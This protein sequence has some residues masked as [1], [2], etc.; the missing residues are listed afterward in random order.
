MLTHSWMLLVTYAAVCGAWWLLNVVVT[1]WRDTDRPRFA[2]PWREVALVL[3]A[4][5][6]VLVLGQLW[7][8]GIRLTLTGGWAPVAE[9]VNQIIIFSPVIAIPIIRRDGWASAW[10]RLGK[11]P[12]RL[13]IG[14]GLALFALFLFSLLEHNAPSWTDAVYGVFSPRRAHLGVQVLLEDLA[15]AILLVR[16]AAAIGPRGAVLAVAGLF[17]AA[18]IPS[19]ITRGDTVAELVG[20]LRDVALGVMVI[21]TVWRSGDIAWVWPVHYALDMTQFLVRAV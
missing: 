16:L 11:L 14:L 19:M 5:A 1:L 13:A 9:S 2:K 4:V 18:H 12:I 7:Q 3:G 8:R 10:L 17:A 20:L 6:A 21:G 15:I